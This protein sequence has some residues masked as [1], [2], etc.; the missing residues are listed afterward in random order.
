MSITIT[1]VASGSLTPPTGTFPNAV[2]NGAFTI[3]GSAGA[4]AV[5]EGVDEQTNWTF[6]FN[7]DP[8]FPFFTAALDFNTIWNACLMENF[9]KQKF[10][11]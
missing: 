4:V 7:P 11:V 8:A 3:T 6:D 5:G 9:L 1:A 10:L 2:V